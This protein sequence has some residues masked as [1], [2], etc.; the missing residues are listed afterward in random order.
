MKTTRHKSN[1]RN[2]HTLIQMRSRYDFADKHIPLVGTILDI[3]CNSCYGLNRLKRNGRILR[4]MDIDRQF[5]DPMN[6]VSLGDI[7]KTELPR[8]SFAG[9]TMFEVIEHLPREEHERVTRKIARALASG[10]VFVT[11]TPNRGVIPHLD[12]GHIS[13]LTVDEFIVLLRTSFRDLQVYALGIHTSKSS[14]LAALR[15]TL[16]SFGVYRLVHALTPSPVLGFFSRRMRG[17]ME[18]KPISELRPGERPQN[19]L[20]IARDQI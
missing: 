20:V 11:S 3:G 16:C 5:V 17:D 4:G 13:E 6:G 10:G 1:H 7:T 14:R 15:T 9:I 2:P 18:V 12:P 8:G 19:T